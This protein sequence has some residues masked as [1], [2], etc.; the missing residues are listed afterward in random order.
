MRKY[1]GI[2]FGDSPKGAQARREAKE[3]DRLNRP[4]L[5]MIRTFIEVVKKYHAFCKKYG[6]VGSEVDCRRLAN[7]LDSY[8]YE[9]R[10]GLEDGLD[11]SDFFDE[12]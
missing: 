12:L 2:R 4:I 6:L 8:Y 9:M 10:D 3:I 11:N 7:M 5:Q 1:R